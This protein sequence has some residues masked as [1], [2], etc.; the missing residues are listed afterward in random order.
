MT[1]T[2][3]TQSMQQAQEPHTQS[4]P[5]RTGQKEGLPPV[6][7]APNEPSA[8]ERA[9][10]ETWAKPF[11]WYG[12]AA[13][14][15]LAWLVWQ[16]R[17]ERASPQAVPKQVGQIVQHQHGK[18]AEIWNIGNLAGGSYLYVVDKTANLPVDKSENSPTQAVDAPVPPVETLLEWA[19]LDGVVRMSKVMDADLQDALVKFATRLA[20]KAPAKES[21]GDEIRPED[22]R[23]R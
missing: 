11:V 22:W 20:L 7:A 4:P 23:N 1:P 10:F 18:E 16:A 9:A 17:A 14:M 21:D 13:S 15:T 3:P 2:K 8:D 12:D 19:V 5:V 6:A